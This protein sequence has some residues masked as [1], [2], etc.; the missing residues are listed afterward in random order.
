MSILG[1]EQRMNLE[2]K[3]CTEELGLPPQLSAPRLYEINTRSWLRRFDVGNQRATLTQVPD[4]YWDNLAQLGF[5]YIWLMG[6]WRICPTT[7]DKYCMAPDLIEAYSRAFPNWTKDDVAGSPYAIDCYE[8]HPAIGDKN[9]LIQLREKLRARE[10][11][12]ILDFVPNHFSADST[13]LQTL[14]ELFLQ[15]PKHFLEHDGHTFYDPRPDTPHAYAH[16]RDPYFPAWLDTVQ[17]NYWHPTARNFMQQQ[18]QEL[19]E[20]CDGVRCDM[21]MLVLNDIFHSTWRDVLDSTHLSCPDH[22][23][24]H[25]AIAAVHNS[26]PNFLFMAE[27]Y[28][29]LE[30]RLLDLGFDFTYDKK[31]MDLLRGISPAEVRQHLSTPPV[32]HDQSIRFLENHDEER[33]LTALGKPKSLAAAVV[34]STI[35]GL[36]LYHDGQLVGHQIRVP[37]QLGKGPSETTDHEVA[38]FYERL[39]KI[40]SHEVFR[41]GHWQMLEPHTAGDGE[42]SFEN[43][44]CWQWELDDR[45]RLIIINYSGSRS[46]A[47]LHLELNNCDEE[48]EFTDLLIN[49]TYKRRLEHL[50]QYGLYVELDPYQAHIFSW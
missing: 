13:L 23:F 9:D 6:V 25:D 22:E 15:A 37:V 29:D 46:K 33:A 45:H 17:V 50:T 27:C 31:L 38:K 19:A 49:R 14:P 48:V 43:F 3:A 20:I 12:L 24:W 35:P 1:V 44:L 7:I 8:P 32:K 10:L 40:T 42:P 47:H 36:Q 41:C 16:G 5:R 30:Q 11:Q 4:S 26:H 34:L 2:L 21:A 28:W 39:L 18:L